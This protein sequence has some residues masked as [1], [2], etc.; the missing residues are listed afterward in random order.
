MSRKTIKIYINN[1][2]RIFDL[3]KSI[4]KIF[5]DYSYIEAAGGLILNDKGKVLM[6]RRLGFW[7]LPK[8]KIEKG[9]TPRKAAIREI[10]EEC[11]I[12]KLKIIEELPS[13]YHVYELNGK[14]ILK[15]TYW[16]M[17]TCSDDTKPV[18]QTEENI[19][20]VKWMS[21]TRMKGINSKNTYGSILDVLS[22]LK[23]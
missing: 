13:T 17:M 9:E 15:R 5:K 2:E 6:I 23:K 18:P 14:K 8:G 20:E 16:F 4:H 7:D 22:N 12:G 21:K 11:G 3:D 19:D 1:I 10:K